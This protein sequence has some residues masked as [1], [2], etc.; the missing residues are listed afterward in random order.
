MKMEKDDE[1]NPFKKVILGMTIWWRIAVAGGT[2]IRQA[3]DA[4]DPKDLYD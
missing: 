2:L 1:N 4:D 3:E